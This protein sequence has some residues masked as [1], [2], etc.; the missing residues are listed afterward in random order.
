M[1]SPLL[2]QPHVMPAAPAEQAPGDFDLSKSLGECRGVVGV[3]AVI[4]EP[5]LGCG[6]K[7]SVRGTVAAAGSR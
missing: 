2:N 4:H 7:R 3:G 1:S 6:Q 5:E